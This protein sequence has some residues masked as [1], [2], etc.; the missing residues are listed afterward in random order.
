MHFL[1]EETLLA[2]DESNHFINMTL[3]EFPFLSIVSFSCF[4]EMGSEERLLYTNLNVSQHPLYIHISVNL[5]LF[6]F[7]RFFL[8]FFLRKN[9]S[10]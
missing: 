9:H 2:Q 8:F 10:L 1:W 7:L 6:N 4:L 5:R 3:Y